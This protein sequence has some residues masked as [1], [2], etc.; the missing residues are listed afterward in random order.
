MKPLLDGRY[1]WEITGL[2]EALRSTAAVWPSSTL[3]AA[4]MPRWRSRPAFIVTF[5]WN[6]TSSSSFWTLH[7]AIRVSPMHTL[8]VADNLH[9]LDSKRYVS[10]SYI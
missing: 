8:I 5:C 3:E 2:S 9:V 7:M 1:T 4:C 6:S 10:S